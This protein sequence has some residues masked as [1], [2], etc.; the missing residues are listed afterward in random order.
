MEHVFALCSEY[1]FSEELRSVGQEVIPIG[2]VRLRNPVS[3]L[4]AR[5]LLARLIARERPDIVISHMSKPLGLLGAALRRRTVPL[6]YYAHGPV[7]EDLY[8]RLAR[9]Y[10]LDFLIGVSEHT[11]ESARQ[12]L[13]FDGPAAI[14]NYPMPWPLTRFGLSPTERRALRAQCDT[15]EDAVV[16]LQATRMDSWKGHADLFAALG[17][18]RE[19][20]RWVHWLI[21]GAQ[22]PSEEAY[23]AG[24]KETAQRLGITDRIRFLGQRRDVPRF[25]GAADIYCQANIGSEGFSLS[26]IEAFSSHLPVVTTD[27]G[28]AREVVGPDVGLLTPVGDGAALAAALTVLVRDDDRRIAMGNAAV[29]WVTHLCDTGQ[30][31]RR[32]YDALAG[33]IARGI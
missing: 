10:R 7:S 3:V 25:L 16:I 23:V 18:M 27:I 4:Q 31:I 8:G 20:P 12:R 26:F 29:P 19:T 6:V 22:S 1:R 5:R 2:P 21:G 11:L 30:Q 9:A 17:R 13:G 15:P 32:L 24:L 14:V 33:A 28:S